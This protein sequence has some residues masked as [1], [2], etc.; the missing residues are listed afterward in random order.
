M[1]WLFL[2]IAFGAA[3]S[4][5]PP[6]PHVVQK[7]GCVS[8]LPAPKTHAFDNVSGTFYVIRHGEKIPAG[9][10]LNTT[11]LARARHLASLFDGGPKSLYT[12]PNAIFTNLFDEEYNSFELARP[13]AEKLGLTI[14]ASYH[15]PAFGYDNFN[16]TIAMWK[17]LA[18][19]GGPVMVVWESWNMIAVVRD[20]GCNSTWLNRYDGWS[21][22][23]A[24]GNQA[25]KY[26]RFYILTM[27]DGQCADL[28]MKWEGFKN[29]KTWPRDVPAVDHF[30]ALIYKSLLLGCLLLL[31]GAGLLSI[32]KRY[33]EPT[34]EP[35]EASLPASVATP[36]LGA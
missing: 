28:Q 18:K 22:G 9:T 32:R 30:A 35:P 5:E 24:P 7:S 29:Y 33:A 10:H 27:R 36:L 4:D 19:T 2:A 16:V 31:V 3:A 13:L 15:R 25:D 1:F 12:P 21:W 11:G 23:H 14:N 34:K 17:A 26:D 8:C 6:P 20:L